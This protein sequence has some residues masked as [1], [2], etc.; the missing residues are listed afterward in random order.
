[1]Y[2]WMKRGITLHKYS[3]IDTVPVLVIFLPRLFFIL[4]CLLF[5]LSKNTVKIEIF[6]CMIVAKRTKVFLATLND[7]K[8]KPVR[9]GLSCR[10]THFMSP[11]FF[12]FVVHNRCA[13]VVQQVFY[14]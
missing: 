14:W 7:E 5:F 1:M 13:V 10:N 12:F 3:Q 4:Y 9:S 6:S 2:Y 11:C 8:K